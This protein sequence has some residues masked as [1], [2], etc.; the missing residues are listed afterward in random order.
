MDGWGG[1]RTD[2][3]SGGGGRYENGYDEDNGTYLNGS[4]SGVKVRVRSRRA[5][6]NAGAGGRGG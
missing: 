5:S 1:E 3:E 2:S 4:W 6:I